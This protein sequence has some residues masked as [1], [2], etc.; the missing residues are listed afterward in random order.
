MSESKEIKG[1]KKE[2]SSYGIQNSKDNN[3]A[4][5]KQNQETPSG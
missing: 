4:L 3:E 1:D 2:K 5:T